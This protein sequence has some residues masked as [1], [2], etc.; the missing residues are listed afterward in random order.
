MDG[1][2]NIDFLSNIRISAIP[3]TPGSLI[4]LQKTEEK[5][6]LNKT[7]FRIINLPGFFAD[8]TMRK[9]LHLFFIALRI[10][11]KPGVVVS[12]VFTN[13]WFDGFDVIVEFSS[14][15]IR[16]KIFKACRENLFYFRESAGRNVDILDELSSERFRIYHATC[17]DF[18]QQNV[19]IV[20]GAIHVYDQETMAVYRMLTLSQYR[21]F[22]CNGHLEAI[23]EESSNL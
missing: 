8:E 4:S 23:E 10:I 2:G 1:Q 13:G 9:I 12:C 15:D 14:A 19:A 11:L 22:K 18:G 5:M 21:E 6:H 16:D 17:A 7:M 20:A 3:C